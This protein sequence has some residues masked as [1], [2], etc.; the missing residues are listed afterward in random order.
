[1][2]KVFTKLLLILTAT[3]LSGC[4]LFTF[5]GDEVKEEKGIELRDY[6]ATAAVGKTYTFDGK[7]FLLYEDDTEKE[8]TDKCSYDYSTLDTSKEGQTS[9]KVKYEGTKYVFSKIAYINVAQL[10]LESI[11]AKDYTATVKVGQT[12]TFDGKVIA[13]YN[14]ASEVDV[15]NKADIGSI[16]TETAGQKDLIISYTEEN[17]SKSVTKK[18]EVKKELVSLTISGYK[19]TYELNEAYSFTGS[20]IAKY[21][22]NTTANVTSKATINCDIDT[23]KLGTYTLLASYTEDGIT[24]ETSVSISVTEHIPVLQSIAAS[25]YTTQVDKGS[26]YTFDGVVMATFDVGE[27]IDVTAACTYT[28]L[29]TSSKGNQTMTIKYTDPSNSK[30]TKS[31]SITVNVI[32]RVTGISVNNTMNLGVGKTKPLNATALPSDANN[33]TLIY[34]STNTNYATVDESGNVTGKA[35]GSVTISIT[36]DDNPLIN[37]EVVVT[38]ST[39]V[40]DAWTIL[41]YMCGSNLES[42]YASSNEGCATADLQEIASVSGQPNDVNIVVQAGGA[43]KWSS[44]Y[45]SVINKDKANRFHLKNKSYVK[46][47]QLDKANMGDQSTLESFLTWGLENYDADKVGIIFWNHGGA[48][49]GCCHDEQFNDMLTVA[50]VDGA[51]KA[52]RTATGFTDK[53]EF[54]GYDC[55][56]MQVQDIAG[57]HS[58]YAKYQLASEESEWGYG[59]SYDAWVGNV[60]T[61]KSTPTI[62]QSAVVG[63]KNDTTSAYNDWGETNDQTLSYLDLSKWDAYE[64]A[65]ETMASTL[66]GVINSSSKWTT[67]SNLLNSCQRFGQSED[68][69]GNT[70]YPFDVFDVGSF[71]TKMKASSTYNGNSTLM[72]NIT[73]V[74][75]ALNNLVGYEWHGSGSSGATGLTLFAPVSGYSSQ[76][77]YTTSSTTLSTWRTLCINRGTWY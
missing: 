76:S 1:M 16:S 32:S 7:V 42:D 28:T 59:W 12:Y 60:F 55:C 62:L 43:K 22:D 77:D 27:P 46:D 35:V 71:C 44:T 21:S 15:T 18:I 70:I 73:S 4:D 20:V 9:F 40:K 51:I 10:K 25:G 57:L 39:V 31:T 41:V 29:N 36:S 17:V 6:T 75:S 49:T 13:K 52:A 54:V 19:A 45:S 63:F 65:W 47:Q 30:N 53:F 3:A 24:K 58:K 48:M 26:T 23:S 37:A 64:T 50:D 34:E 74:Q 56:L 61:D 38:V 33:K 69:Y 72:S 8:V 68:Y 67:F 2:K 66:S 11:D 5:G 14:D